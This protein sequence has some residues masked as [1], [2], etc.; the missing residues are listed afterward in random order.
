MINYA[1]TIATYDKASNKESLY[2]GLDF[3][4]NQVKEADKN[5][6]EWQYVL[7]WW[8]HVLCDI[9]G[10]EGLI[11]FYWLY[12]IGIVSLT[13]LDIGVIDTLYK[14]YTSKSLLIDDTMFLETL[15]KT[16]KTND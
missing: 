14:M 2:E 7:S 15:K 16:R 4:V 10:V 13:D 3:L 12:K 11:V 5:Q 9:D 1:L 6:I 8:T